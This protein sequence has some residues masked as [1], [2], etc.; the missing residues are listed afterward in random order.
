MMMRSCAQQHLCRMILIVQACLATCGVQVSLTATAE[1]ADTNTDTAMQ[2]LPVELLATSRLVGF[3][4]Q[5]HIPAVSL[6]GLTV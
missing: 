5:S 3:I 6:P 2:M 4:E 1:H